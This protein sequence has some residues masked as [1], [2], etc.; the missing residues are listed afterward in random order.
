MIF[1]SLFGKSRKKDLGKERGEQFK[2]A[3]LLANRSLLAAKSDNQAADTAVEEVT[4]IK[5]AETIMRESK[6]SYSAEAHVVDAMAQKFLPI[7]NQIYVY[8]NRYMNDADV[9][10]AHNTTY[11]RILE[12]VLAGVADGEP[13]RHLEA[14]SDFA[15][16]ESELL[17]KVNKILAEFWSSEA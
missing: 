9:S 8:S 7:V 12:I 14:P 16:E 13:V 4:L 3:W 2:Q 11:Q 6:E 10:S 5:K 1:E 17:L 15:P